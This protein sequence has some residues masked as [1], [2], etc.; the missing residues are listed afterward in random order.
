MN[1]YYLQI[2]TI[3]INKV[4]IK[5]VHSARFLGVYIDDK[6]TCKDHISYILA[7]SISILHR[8]KWTC[9]SRAL[10]LL[11]Y[12][13]VLPYFSQ[14]AITWGN[15]YYTNILPIFYKQ[16]SMIS[17]AKYNDQALKLF[18]NLDILTIFQLVK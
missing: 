10:R 15:T 11:Y 5:Y 18:H 13:L 3:T 12:I 2:I 1:A 14:C 6:M 7:K 4:S 8:V 16:R 17:N 9:D